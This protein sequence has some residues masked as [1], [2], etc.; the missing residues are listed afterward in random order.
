MQGA[1]VDRQDCKY[2]SLKTAKLVLTL[3]T[4]SKSELDDRSL[5]RFL[6][7]LSKEC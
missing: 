7:G 4:K 5:T 3:G 6:T 1:M 2:I